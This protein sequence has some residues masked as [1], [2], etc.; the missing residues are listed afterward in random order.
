MFNHLKIIG[1]ERLYGTFGLTLC[2]FKTK[3]INLYIFQF[4]LKKPWLIPHVERNYES[5]S[6][7]YGWLFFYFSKSTLAVIY[8]GEDDAKLT[9]RDGKHYYVFKV[10]NYKERVIVDTYIKH[11]INFYVESNGNGT[12]TLKL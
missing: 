9:D 7:L 12:V 2:N 1:K 5:K 3:V 6:D 10:D 8:D 4:S 11:G